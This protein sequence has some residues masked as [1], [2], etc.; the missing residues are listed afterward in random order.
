VLWDLVDRKKLDGLLST[1]TD[2]Q[3]RRRHLNVL[4]DIFTLF[5]YSSPEF[6]VV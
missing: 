5:Q 6:Q 4:Y 2:A 3:Q 1:S